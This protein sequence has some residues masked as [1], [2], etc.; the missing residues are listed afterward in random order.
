[1]T[2]EN[3]DSLNENPLQVVLFGTHPHKG[4]FKERL[5]KRGYNVSSYELSPFCDAKFVLTH[6]NNSYID[7]GAEKWLARTTPRD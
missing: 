5:E 2:L 6:G 4:D 7:Q 1:M 3:Q